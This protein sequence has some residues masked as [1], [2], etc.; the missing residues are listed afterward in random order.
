AREAIDGSGRITVSVRPAEGGRVSL[1][2]AD[3]GVGIPPDQ[4]DR[5]FEPHFSTRTSGT[6]LGLAIV[7]RIV[8]SWGAV[9][10]VESVVG[11]GTTVELLMQAAD[12]ADVP[13][14][15]SFATLPT[16]LTVCLQALEVAMTDLRKGEQR[17]S[18]Q[19]TNIGHPSGK[20]ESSRERESMKGRTR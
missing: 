2:V 15:T 7:K 16:P 17:G 5:I 13:A 4:I 20:D 14:G 1:R 10:R 9:I 18:G 8:D 3:D 12:A 11:Q 19:T 6:G